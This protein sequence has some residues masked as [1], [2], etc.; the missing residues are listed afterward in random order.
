MREDVRQQ[1]AMR[2]SISPEQPVPADH[3]LRPMR[4]MVNGAMTELSAN[5]C[6]LR[7]IG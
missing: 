6:R 4:I 7:L 5:I 2:S 1:A 3:P